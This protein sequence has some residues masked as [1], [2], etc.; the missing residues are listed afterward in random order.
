[1]CTSVSLGRFF[2]VLLVFLSVVLAVLLHSHIAADDAAITFR[3]VDRAASGKGW[4]YNDHERVQGFSN[5]FYTALLSLLRLAGLDVETAAW[6]LQLLLYAAVVC[7]SYLLASRLAGPWGGL[8]AG[9]GLLASGFFRYQALDGMEASLSAF[10]GLGAIFFMGMDA[11]GTSGVLLGLALVNK[12]DAGF[13]ALAIG[14]AY[15]LA[16]RKI[17][18]KTMLVS[19][20]TALPWF[21]FAQAYYGS[22]LPNSMLVK[23][24]LHAHGSLDRTWI[25]RIL[26][27]NHGVL[28]LFPLL[29]AVLAGR[30]WAAHRK[31]T[32]L[33]SLI[34]LAAHGT[35]FSLVDLGDAYPWYATVLFPP[36]MALCGA[37][38]SA[39]WRFTSWRSG[40]GWLVSAAVLFAFVI[41]TVETGY[42]T[43]FPDL[44]AGNPIHPWEA[45]DLDRRLAGVF[46]DSFAGKDEIVSSAFGWV[47][48]ESRRPFNDTS[49]LNTI[50]TLEPAAYV[51]NHGV[52]YTEGS[53]APAAPAGYVPL[54]TFDL[55]GSL[56][57]GYSWFTVFG[58]PDSSIARKGI[59]FL[60]R[61]M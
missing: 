11:P 58:R 52:P 43:T 61:R 37:G 28:L 51:V 42:R 60:E 27:E 18:W 50:H 12:L 39:L 59:R 57:P 6:F 20:A 2:L 36:L 44:A 32:L 49:L 19:G 3:Y 21:V 30:R 5:P 23:M 10:L 34:W 48:Y 8:L 16:F 4:T 13:L 22:V 1:M 31:F 46:L 38:A 15:L 14:A 33:A 45:F 40:Y 53:S 54:A 24:N 17:P 26:L 9:T 25:M 7:L 47:A 55:A 29:T 41:P 35:A 56:F